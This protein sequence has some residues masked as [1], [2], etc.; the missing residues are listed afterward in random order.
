MINLKKLKKNLLDY[1][2]TAVFIVLGNGL[3]AFLVA[4]F[5]IPHDIIMGGTTGIAIVLSRVL[6]V[7]TA[8]LVL[9]QNVVL[10]ILGLFVLGKKFFLTTVASSLLYPVMLGIMQRIPNIESL[11]DDSLLASLFAGVLMGISLG[12]VMRVGSSTGGMDILNL[13]FHKWLHIPVSILVWITDTVVV[14]GQALFSDPEKIMLGIVVLVLESMVLD[15]VM[16]FGKAQT[17]LYIISDN[18][19]E[20]RKR[21]LTE[22]NF[23]C[24]MS[25]IETGN[26]GKKQMAVMCII[27]TRKLYE[28]TELIYSIDSTAFITIT[29]IKE[30]RGRGFTAERKV[31]IPEAEA[32]EK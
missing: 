11:T 18:Y 17:Q 21:I 5:I 25:L 15:R 30:V 28:T 22:L 6:P 31:I 26:L 20:I 10:L 4:A 9:I 13:V 16:T 3:L 14:G 7:E 24:T 27:P 19:Q 29:K 32:K 1:L 2:K 23:G 12:L 8:V